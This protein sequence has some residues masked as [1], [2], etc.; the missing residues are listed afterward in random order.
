MLR[1]ATLQ[2]P[3]RQPTLDTPAAI[4]EALRRMSAQKEAWAQKVQWQRT[5]R[6]SANVH[7]SQGWLLLK[8]EPTDA[9]RRV[10][11]S[12]DLSLHPSHCENLNR[13]FAWIEIYVYWNI[14][15]SFCKPSERYLKNLTS[16]QRHLRSICIDDPHEAVSILALLQNDQL[17]TALRRRR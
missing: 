10:A 15:H 4:W 13:K 2:A 9:S 8:A 6:L 11:A 17:V 7:D 5:N 12:T 1:L 16:F 3:A 14:N